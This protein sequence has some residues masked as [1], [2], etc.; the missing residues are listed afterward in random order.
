MMYAVFMG[1][2][3]VVQLFPQ[4][5]AAWPQRLLRRTIGRVMVL[6]SFATES[7]MDVVIFLTTPMR[8]R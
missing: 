5:R 7:S 6:V 2:S 3:V 8:K 4:R 1:Q